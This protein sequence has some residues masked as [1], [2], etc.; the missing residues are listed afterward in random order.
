[1]SYLS[2]LL[3]KKYTGYFWGRAAWIKQALNVCCVPKAP[4]Q[5]FM[6]RMFEVV[7]LIGWLSAIDGSPWSKME[8]SGSSLRHAPS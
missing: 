3:Q 2:S 7:V 5:F 1:M 8:Y 4:V 6:R